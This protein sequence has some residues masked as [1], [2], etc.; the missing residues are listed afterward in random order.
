MPTQN[1][2]IT[3]TLTPSTH[4]LLRELSSLTGNSMSSTLADLLTGNEPVFLRMVMVLRAAK[5]VQQEGKASMLEALAKAQA[6]IEEQLGLSLDAMDEGTK[7]LLENAE[8]VRRR[9]RRGHPLAGE[10]SARASEPTPISNRGVRSTEDPTKQQ[11]KGSSH[12]QV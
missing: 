2:R 8:D 9:G 7:S 12:G 4:S 6:R 10:G 1:P 3:I 11:A 5:D